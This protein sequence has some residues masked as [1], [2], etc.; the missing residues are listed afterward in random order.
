M[1]VGIPRVSVCVRVLIKHTHAHSHYY[2]C[3]VSHVTRER[4]LNT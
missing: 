1:L 3:Y 4:F 2:A